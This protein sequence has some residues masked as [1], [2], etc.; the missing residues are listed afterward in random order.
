MDFSLAKETELAIK[1]FREFAEQEIKPFVEEMDE[2]EKMNMDIVHKLGEVGML[3]IPFPKEY[4]GCGSDYMTNAV[5]VEELSKISATVAGIISV[6]ASLASTGIYQFGTEEQKKKYL[7]DLLSGKKIGAFSLT[8][9]GA[10]SDAA[11]QQT[12]AVLDGDE[13]VINGTKI[14][15]TN[16]GFADTFIIICMTDKSKGNRGISAFIVEKGTP[17]FIVGKEERKM[18]LRASSTTEL[19]FENCRVP[20][21]NLLGQE[22]KGLKIALT[23][24]DGGRVTIAAQ[25]V[26][27]AQ[28]AID[29]TLK[30]IKERKQFGKRIS[31]FQNTQFKLAEM[32]TKTDLARLMLY[33]AVTLKDQNCPY[34]KEAAMAKYF[35]SETAN[36]VTR[37]A[38]QLHGGYGY[39]REYPVE[40]MMRDAKI[41]E[42]YEGTTEIQKMV[43][44]GFMK[45]N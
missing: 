31:Q 34:S 44:A 33:K 12:Q 10:G 11:G 2:T 9:P 22:N 23:L 35:S 45:V 20:K 18:G 24:L 28:G 16:G 29:E 37:M 27:I 38:V 41:T 13:Y 4:G 5:C 40:R 26:G 25:C 21:E 30:Y 32:Q 8:E 43:I 17:G 1:M 7:P 39:T 6:H 36:E 3:G 42:I 19:I 15:C 14:F